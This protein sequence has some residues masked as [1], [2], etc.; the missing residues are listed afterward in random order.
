MN[1]L[2]EMSHEEIE[3]FER[4]KEESDAITC[5]LFRARREGL[6]FEVIKAFAEDY[7]SQQEP[8]IIEAVNTALYEWDC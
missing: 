8:N 1:D 5:M 3:F 4:L 2:S 6:L 7:R